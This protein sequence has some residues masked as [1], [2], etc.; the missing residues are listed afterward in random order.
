MRSV[1]DVSTLEYVQSTLIKTVNEVIQIQQQ[2]VS[3]REKAVTRLKDLQ[4]NY[5]KIVKTD[6]HRIATK[7]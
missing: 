7:K 4:D 6:S 5:K 1:I 2:G 3:E